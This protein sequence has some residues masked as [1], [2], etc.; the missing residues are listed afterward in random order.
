MEPF[1]EYLKQAREKKGF[2]LE[3]LA[4]QTRIPERH[5]Q[6]LESDDFGNLPAKVFAKGF[7][8][9]YAKA[10]GLNEE[11][12]LQR[13]LQT[14]G[15]F[16]E[17]SQPE[18]PHVQVKLEAAPRQNIN[19]TLVVVVLLAIAAGAFWYELPKQQVSPIALPE[20]EVS[21]TIKAIE[22][23]IPSVSDPEKPI[24][25]ATPIDSVPNLPSP[26]M[27]VPAEPTPQPT[28]PPP[29]EQMSPTSSISTTEEKTTADEGHILEIEAT[30]L[31]WVVVQSDQQAPNEALLQP[32]QRITWEAN[33]QFLL[34]LGNAAGVVIQ[35]NGQPQGP[36]GKPGQ[37]V[38]DIRLKP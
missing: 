3:R 23:P 35:L 27:P 22:E 19:W 30:Q 10:L 28:P 4:S 18:H 24:T 6:A 29:V 14:S 9:S 12:A 8:R 1:G 25:P 26:S 2:S 13:F 31:T 16:Y 15:T 36:F 5:L 17:R 38:R 21:S 32:G 34:T 7:V 20:P 37:V 11:E 33:K